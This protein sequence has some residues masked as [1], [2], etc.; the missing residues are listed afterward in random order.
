[1]PVTFG[2]IPLLL[3][4]L[5]LV[6]AALALAALRRIR[7]P[8]RS[9]IPIALGLMLLPLAAGRMTWSAPTSGEIVVMVDLSPSTRTAAYRDPSALDQRIAQLLGDRPH[10]RM[11]FADEH[12]LFA[13]D[14]LPDPLPNP[15]PDLPAQ[16][17]HFAPPPDAAAVVLFSD[18]R[19]DPPV[20]AP[21]TFVIVDPALRAPIDG[22]ISTLTWIDRRAVV[23]LD[24]AAERTFTWIGAA[25]SDPRLLP[26]GRHVLTAAPAGHDAAVIAQLEGADPWPENDTLALAPAPQQQAVRWWIGNS[27]PPGNQWLHLAP[28]EVPVDASAWLNASVVVL[29][30]IAADDL[31]GPQCQRLAQYV[32]DL[33]GT[34]I[35]LG[36]ERAFAAGGYT[37]T[38]L[39]ALS[40]LASHPPAP[41]RHWVLL[42]DASGSMAALQDAGGRMRFIAATDALAAAVAR[43]PAADLVSI[44]AFAAEVD[45]WIEGQPVESAQSLALPPPHA[46]PHGP[47]NLQPAL[48]ALAAAPADL[49]RQVLILTDGQTELTGLPRLIERFRATDTRLWLLAIG[50]GNAID[51]LTQL[52]RDSGGGVLSESDTGRW[53]ERLEQLV[54]QA[55]PDHLMR[56]PADPRAVASALPLPQV[57]IGLWN[58][59]W[60]K[61]DAQLLVEAITDD[62][63]AAWP[64]LA[65]WRRG[66]GRVLAAAWQAGPVLVSAWAQELESLPGDPRFTITWE[67]ER[68]LRIHIDA[69]EQE[70]CLNNLSLRAVFQ[71][72]TGRL[73]H[74][75]PQTAPGRYE[76]TL[77]APREPGTV[78][79]WHEDRLLRRFAIPGRYAPEF[80]AIGNDLPAMQ[81]LADITG[82]QVIAPDHTAP[83]NL[84]RPR[85]SLDLTAWLTAAAFASLAA[86]I[87]LLRR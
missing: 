3:T 44:G 23:T 55:A 82:G 12:P 22:R 76:L 16:R 48:D 71:L 2:S 29:D 60:L 6:L 43:L 50:Q 53:A 4:A 36:G 32:Q 15:L 19:F 41:M 39:D 42:T 64:L 52:A 8:R 78:T 38:L 83:L 30:N 18:G 69:L 81:H 84:P 11:Y 35:L 24:L 85:R 57:P 72:P 40:P 21:P 37:G 75:L 17:T 54:H 47:T 34:L 59:T 80:E 26:P 73:A 7:L 68:E 58:R 28:M 10:R 87:A 65:H 74:D 14:P 1:M 49:P 61:Q 9:G 67:A 25:D 5:A 56:T 27:A 63:E 70:A 20:V 86:G 45:W 66:E 13:L 51:A 31:S 33:G 79:V 62:A 46:Q 77:P